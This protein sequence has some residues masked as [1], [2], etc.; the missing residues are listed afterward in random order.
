[1]CAWVIYLENKLFCFVQAAR[2]EQ[3]AVRAAAEIYRIIDPKEQTLLNAQPF[4]AA[5]A[6]R[7]A[8]PSLS[9]I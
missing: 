1:M 2:D 9:L 7:A 6:E 3:S 5:L 4:R 8:T